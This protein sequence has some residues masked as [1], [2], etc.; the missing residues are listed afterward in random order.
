[1]RD[2]KKR[3]EEGREIINKHPRHDLSLSE[4]SQIYEMI[5]NTEEY[6]LPYIIGKVFD[7]GVSVGSRI[8][9]QN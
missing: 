5:D 1:M 6:D 7:L 9:K 3:A 2:I 8:A 4:I